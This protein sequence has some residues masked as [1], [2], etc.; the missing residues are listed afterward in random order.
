MD[1]KLARRAIVGLV[2]VGL[3]LNVS[4]TAGADRTIPISGEGAT[5]LAKLDDGALDALIVEYLSANAVPG[6]TVAVTKGSRLVWSKGYGYAD[7]ATDIAMQ[8]QHRS[9]IGS[10]S[11]FVTTIGAMQLVE[12]GRIDLDQHVYG[13]GASALWGS[14]WGASPGVI[15]T[16]DGAL[17]NSDDYFQAMVAGVNELGELF[18]PADH[19]DEF[20]SL[21]WA[22]LTQ[23]AYEQEIATTLDRASGIQV[24]HLLSHTSGLRSSGDGAKE[25]AAEHFGKSEDDVTAAEYHQAVL[26]GKVGEFFLHDPGTVEDYSNHGFSVAG[27]LIEEA[28]NEDSY[29]DYIGNH[30]LAPLGLFDVVPNNMSISDLDAIPYEADGDPGDLDPDVVSRLGLS[31]GGWSASARD[32]ARIMCSTDHSSNHLRSLE[33]ETVDL[34]GMDAAP[35]AAGVNPLGWDSH[36]DFELTKN[37]DIPSGGSSRIMKFLPGAFAGSPDAEINVAVA[38]NQ[39]DSVPS[40]SLLRDI[41][42][43]AAAATIPEHYDLFD[44]SYACRVEG[45]LGVASTPRTSPTTPATRTTSPSVRPPR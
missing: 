38:V 6:A 31:T 5:A 35:G 44:P 21:N 20:P 45:D 28:S 33:P 30:L 22:L 42:E 24:R 10:V 13:S 7:T 37:G 25:A 14:E 9:K 29:R 32:L 36:S 18:P 23:A 19:L 17:E 43:L 39:A 2:G 16:A 40:S 26:M 8:P 4:G 41:A 11:K 27:L 12:D 34:M 15:S 3:S 1:A